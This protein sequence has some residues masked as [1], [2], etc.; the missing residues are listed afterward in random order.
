MVS[1]PKHDEIPDKDRKAQD[2]IQTL[3]DLNHPALHEIL[4]EALDHPHAEVRI[5][6]A[7]HLADLFQDARAVPAL[8]EA[9]DTADRQVRM[10]AAEALWE[11]GDTNSAALITLLS[12]AHGQVRDQIAGALS[13]IGWQADEP[14][15]EMAYRIAIRDWKGCIALGSAAVPALLEVLRDREESERRA[16]A[17]VLGRIGDPRAV[18]GLIQMLGDMNGGMFGVGDRV[19]DVAAEALSLI[20]TSEAQAAVD[21]WVSS[22]AAGEQWEV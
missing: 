8:A 3:V 17:W 18:S 1:N 19:C 10:S 14:A 22:A 21:R 4:V 12:G 13:R 16:A 11:I 20:G 2:T 15:D 6:A 9:L 5:A 7:F